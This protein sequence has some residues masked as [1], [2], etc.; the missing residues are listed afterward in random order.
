MERSRSNDE[1]R[2]RRSMNNKVPAGWLDYSPLNTW[3]ENT[4]FVPFKCPLRSSILRNI[5]KQDRFSLNDLIDRLENQGRK[6]GL[7]ID[8]TD[9]Y[10]YYDYRDVEDMGIE[11][12]KI[13]VPGHQDVSDKS[14][15]KFFHVVNTF[16]RD[17]RQNGIHCTHG[18]NRSGYFI[19]RYLIEIL[20]QQPDNA[21]AE[22][23]LNEYW[24]RKSKQVV[25][26]Q[27]ERDQRIKLQ[28]D[29]EEL[30]RIER[31][32][33]QQLYNGDLLDAYRQEQSMEFELVLETNPET[34]D[35]IIEVAL[36]LVIHMK[37]HQI[38]GVKFLWNQV[39]ESTSR[40]AS[41]I[42]NRTQIDQGGS[43]AILA[44]CMGLGKT[45]TTIVLVHTLLR[46]STLTHVRRILI[47][48]PINTSINWKHEFHDWLKDLEPTINVY[49]FNNDDIRTE[50]REDFLRFWY[51]NGGV[52]L[53][54][55]E[56]YRQLT[57]TS[58]DK[59]DD[60][61][62]NILKQDKKIPSLIEQIN[63]DKYR[64]YL[65]NPGPDLIICDE[66][67]IIKNP[68]S[69]IA[70]TLAKVRTRRRIVLTGTP[71]QNNLKEYFSMVNFC[72]P[73][74]LGTEREFSYLFRKPIEAGQHRDSLPYQ[75][76]TMRSR[77]SDLN[78][79]LKNII[80]RR[81]FEVLRT[82]L[83]PKFEYAVKIKCRPTQRTLYETY[84]NYHR[85][86]SFNDNLKVAKL[87]SD[88]QYLMKIWTHPWLL[89]PYFTGYYNKKTKN[90][91]QTPVEHIF[92]DDDDDSD[93]EDDRI[94]EISS[95]QNILSLPHTN[96]LNQNYQENLSNAIKQQWWFNMFDPSNSQFDFQLSGKIVILKAILD[97][98]ESI[99]DK[100]L[101]FTR[102]L[103]AL[104]YLEQCLAYWSEQSSSSKWQKDIDYFRIDGQVA[105]KHRAANIKL[106]ND[107]NNTR[108]RLF[109]IST[110]A[111]GLGINL[112]SANR[113]IILD[114]S[115]NPAHDLQAMFRSYRLGQVKPVYIYRLIVKGTMEEKI[116]KRQIT[117]QAMFHRVVDAK[118][119]ARHFTY[120]ELAQLYEYDFD[121][122][123]DPI[124][125]Y[126]ANLVQDKVLQYLINKHSDTIVSYCEHDSFLIHHDEEN[127]MIEEQCQPT[128]QL[129][130]IPGPPH[131]FFFGHLKTLWASKRY[132]IQLQE[133][134]RKYGSIYGLYEGTRPLYVVSD[135]DFLHEVFIKQFSSF[136]SRRVLF[137]ARMGAGT[138]E[139]LFGASGTT[140][141]RQRHIVN[142][143]FSLGK[144]K[145]MLPV[146]NQ[147]IEILMN[148][149]SILNENNEEFNINDMYKRMTMDIIWRAGFGIE[150]DMQN[151][152]DNIYLKK[153]AKVVDINYDKLF[154]VQLSN[155][156]PFLKPFLIIFF[157]CQLKIIR[158][159][160]K[161]I[162]FMNY[163]MEELAPFWIINRA[164]EIVDYRKVHASE[165]K[166]VDLLQLMIDAQIPDE[167]DKLENMEEDTEQKILHPDEITGNI[168]I[169]MIAGY[170]TTSTTLAYCTYILAKKPDIQEKLIAEIDTHLGQKDYEDNYDLVTNMSYI[171]IFIREVLRVF[172]IIIQATSRECN[173]TTTICG[174]QIE[175]GSVIQAD[176]LSIHFS[177]DLW[178]P[179]DPNEFIPERHLTKRHPIS[180]MAFGN[181]PRNCVGMR[182]AIMELKIC[183]TH[184]LSQYNILPGDKLDE[185]FHLTELSVINP[186]AIFIKL[187]KRT[188]YM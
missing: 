11:Y 91:K 183:L 114:T 149:L 82:Y 113:V 154:I 137:L 97:E 119:L 24:D 77:V 140:W 131:Q 2:N 60:Q 76:K 48:C 83:P 26:E 105:I 90:G 111:G 143:T 5:N 3:I 17:N 47:L 44:H 42:D 161:I 52:L 50:K 12:C 125:K 174:H 4:R 67:H 124:D 169:F 152:I 186:E 135:V 167:K 84:I 132:S 41:S 187:K 45:F 168:L 151:N 103:I 179:E 148:K 21:I 75:V 123:H 136:H 122:H 58:D 166:H 95:T 127:L 81:G 6:I 139:T 55:Y 181:G 129:R 22:K 38:E 63:I 155:L 160:G 171:D 126:D 142:R 20:G 13:R 130:N 27:I 175:E 147:C 185:H 173:K 29:R 108:S 128:E 115:W 178:G 51:E 78:T 109:L 106:F 101:V 141:R 7:I 133:W 134:T 88:Y 40:I 116:Y 65:R 102:S 70:C 1:I 14:C 100:L 35:I 164:Q 177:P 138:P 59:P 25:K 87:F 43:G 74:F 18:I 34:N 182:F 57:F 73:N 71:M 117:K 79:L 15:Q 89:Q 61:I 9:T 69:A 162:P 64:K 32:Q 98:C 36:L 86:N 96:I 94:N 157:L 53:M 110:T 165:K 46:Y 56:M 62:R 104:D 72:K 93:D 80:H 33:K 170:E 23:I 19:V 172:P 85:M 118:Q 92:D 66:G 10:R 54:G 49:L 107:A 184:L 120:D 158:I 163:F 39:F 99:G 68:R 30:A 112:F 150:S 188:T 144:M 28:Q 16:L 31:A 156:M 159:L 153:S 176:I 145:L 37:P 121:M 180:W 8:L 146:V